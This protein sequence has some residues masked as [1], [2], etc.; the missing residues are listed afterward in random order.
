MIRMAYYE[1]P[2]YVPLLRR[3]YERWEELEK[4]TGQKLLYITGGLYM[5][6]RQSEIIAGT[7][8]DAPLVTM[9][10]RGSR[11]TTP[12]AVIFRLS[13]ITASIA[14]RLRVGSPPKNWMKLHDPSFA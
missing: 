6:H 9:P 13:S 12:S 2:D 8:R 7:F 14:E 1:H 3:A 10:N 11:A 4:R 5:G